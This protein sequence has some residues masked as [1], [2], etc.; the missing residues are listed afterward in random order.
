MND[1]AAEEAKLLQQAMD[2]GRADNPDLDPPDVK[3][4][5]DGDAADR[6]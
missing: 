6:A 1:N 4:A 2:A 3:E 5:D